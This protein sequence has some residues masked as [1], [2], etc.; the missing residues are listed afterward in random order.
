[1]RIVSGTTSPRPER[2]DG[3]LELADDLEGRA[4]RADRL[5]RR[6]VVREELLVEVAVDD[7]DPRPLEH[8]VLV[9]EAP[10]Q[11]PHVLADLLRSWP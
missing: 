5:V 10:A 2:V 4:E 7:A 1:M 11:D 3:L 6:L 8:V 9:D